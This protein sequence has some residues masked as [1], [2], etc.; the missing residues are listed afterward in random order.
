MTVGRWHYRAKIFILNILWICRNNL[1]SVATIA[2]AG[3]GAEAS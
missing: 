3:D 1:H 2:G